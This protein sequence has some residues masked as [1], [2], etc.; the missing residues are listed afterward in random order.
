[1]GIRLEESGLLVV[2]I[3]DLEAVPEDHRAEFERY[4]HYVTSGRGRHIYFHRGSLPALNRKQRGWEIRGKGHV[5]APPSRH[6][7]GAEYR[8]SQGVVVVYPTVPAFVEEIIRSHTTAEPGSVRVNWDRLPAV[9]I[10]RIPLS[11]D[12]RD[13]IRFGAKKGYRSE[14]LWRVIGDLVRAGCDNDTIAAI[15]RNPE[16]LISAKVLEKTPEQRRRYVEYQIAKMRAELSTTQ[17]VEESRRD[18]AVAVVVAEP[19]TERLTDLGNAKRLVRRHGKDLRYCPEWGKWLVYDGRRWVV[20][21]TGEVMRRAKETVQSMY[22]EAAQIADEGMRKALAQWAM[23]P[24]SASRLKAMVELAQS[25]PGIPVTPSELDRD[26]WLLNCLNGTIDL[27]TGQLS[28]HRREDLITKLVP[29]E[30]DSDAKAPLWEKFLHEIMN[31]DEE[32]IR[33]L[34]RAVGYSLTGFTTEQK[35]FLLYGTGANGKNVFLETIRALLGDYAQQAEFSTFLQWSRDGDRVRNDLARMVGKRF[36]SAVEMEEGGRLCEA[37]IKQITGGDTITARFLCKEYFE[38]RPVLKLWL[39]ANHK[40]RIRG[41]DYAIWRRVYMIHFAVTIPPE[42][43]DRDLAERLR[44]E[45]LKGIL[46]WAVRGCL[47]WQQR[48]LDA[49]RA[50]VEATEQYREEQDIVG[51]FIADCCV[52][53][54]NARATT[55]EL[56]AAFKKWCEDVGETPLSQRAFGERLNARNFAQRKINGKVWRIGIGLVADCEAAQD[57][58]DAGVDLVDSVDLSPKSSYITEN[59]AEVSGEK[60]RRSTRSTGEGTNPVWGAVPGQTGSLSLWPSLKPSPFFLLGQEPL[61]GDDDRIEWEDE[62]GEAV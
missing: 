13:L 40:P 1:M 23:K 8:W 57:K 16:H 61:D 24:E 17:P 19:F 41:T 6:R 15:I 38:F 35:M 20:D 60:S 56:Y 14:A 18:A 42:K 45:E 62:G 50:V 5:V 28:P 26:P 12:T 47:E 7:E 2:D 9:D 58:E 54:P 55:G 11:E 25:E 29:V 4:E 27:Q 59:Q 39:A 51:Q 31:G 21:Q 34:Q 10:S 44:Q 3:D 36:V 46:S 48:G 49:P 22:Q 32:L 52:E 30:Y 43:R 37:V 53:G 33:F